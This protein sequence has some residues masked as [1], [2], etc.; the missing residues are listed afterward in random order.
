[1]SGTCEDVDFSGPDVYMFIWSGTVQVDSVDFF[2]F[3]FFS[4]IIVKVLD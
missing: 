2:F 1:M 3:F 4:V